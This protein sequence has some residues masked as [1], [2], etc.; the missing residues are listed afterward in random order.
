MNRGGLWKSFS[1]VSVEVQRTC[2]DN[3]DYF[4]RRTRRDLAREQKKMQTDFQIESARLA[5]S[6]GDELSRLFSDVE[7]L[8]WN[9]SDLPSSHDINA[10]DV[11]NSSE[12]PP[13]SAEKAMRPSKASG[14]KDARKS[15]EGSSIVNENFDVD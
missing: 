15:N 12:S 8:L 3:V 5:V 1:S 7:S 13:A 4:R 2:D 14:S 10:L 9:G 11:D 6:A